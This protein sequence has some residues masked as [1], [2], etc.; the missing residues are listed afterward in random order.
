VWDVGAAYEK[1]GKAVKAVKEG[2]KE[3]M[4]ERAVKLVSYIY[5]HSKLLC[6]HRLFLQAGPSINLDI[7][8]PGLNPPVNNA[9][10]TGST[11]QP[12]DSI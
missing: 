8:R 9:P 1:N 12:R 6:I 10:Q 5:G 2:M 11:M 3:R 7:L 4:N